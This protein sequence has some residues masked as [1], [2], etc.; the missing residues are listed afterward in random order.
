MS[1]LNQSGFTLVELTITVVVLGIVLTSVI[2]LFVNI[3]QAQT[4]TRF[5]ETST[6]AAQTEIESLRTIN[7]NNL[8][9]GTTIDFTNQLPSSLPKGS[10]GT[11]TVSE[12]LDGLRRVDV[13]VTYTYKGKTRSVA[14]S[15]LIG[16]LGIT[17]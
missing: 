9:P 1:K 5:L 6:Y 13:S 8:T 15:S 17:Q 14:L 16:V 7:Y 10:T 3:Q 12:P 2:S 4:H 11:V